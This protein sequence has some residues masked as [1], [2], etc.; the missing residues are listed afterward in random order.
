VFRTRRAED[1]GLTASSASAAGGGTETLLVVENEAPIRSLLSQGLERLGYTVLS[2]ESGDVALALVQ[3]HTGPIALVITD[4]VMPD[5]SG[6]ELVRRLGAA[7]P[8]LRTLFM[9]GY[10]DDALGA[11][12]ELPADVNFI[13]KPFSPTALA[14][15]VREILDRAQ[16]ML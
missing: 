9:S 5:M 6:P 16:S 2:A 11:E 7:R 12:N 1:A 14:R 13:Q 10:A 4:V 15:R 8:G 3:Q